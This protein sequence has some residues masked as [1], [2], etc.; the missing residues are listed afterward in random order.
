MLFP[1]YIYCTITIVNSYAYVK[2]FCQLQY[3]VYVHLFALNSI[4]STH[5]QGYIGKHIFH[6][7]RLYHIFIIRL[8]CFA[9]ICILSWDILTFYIIFKICIP[10]YLLFVKRSKI[11]WVLIKAYVINSACQYCFVSSPVEYTAF[12]FWH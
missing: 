6:L 11:I 10:H 1:V 3:S 5:F 9:I 2:P 7:V 12:Q 8:G 4:D